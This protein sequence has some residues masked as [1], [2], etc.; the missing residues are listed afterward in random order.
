MGLTIHY[1]LEYSGK[2][3][4][5]ILEALRQKAMDLPF[6]EVSP[7]VYH[8]KGEAANYQNH[9]KDSVFFWLLIQ[10]TAY[11]EL[12]YGRISLCVLPKEV[13][14]FTAWPGEE[15]EE[16]N[17]GLAKYPAVVPYRGGKVKTKLG[18]NWRWKSFCKTQY[19]SKISM[20]HFL[21]C[22]FSVCQLLKE[23]KSWGC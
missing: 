3:P 1:R 16:A 5:K 10:A 22:H 23:A 18:N 17:F 6:A 14:L 2:E 12:D 21:R 9:S 11:V 8:F 7:K 4:A 13:Y 19:A 20:E 15:C